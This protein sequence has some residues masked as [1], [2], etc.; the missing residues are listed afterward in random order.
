MSGI[1]KP[2]NLPFH[3][4]YLSVM[5]HAH[6]WRFVEGVSDSSALAP[7]TYY[8]TGYKLDGPWP[9]QYFV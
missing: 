8:F 4:I 7:K 1:P 9:I 2:N 3:E 5:G 6:V